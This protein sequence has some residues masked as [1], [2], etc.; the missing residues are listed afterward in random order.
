MGEFHLKQGMM[1]GV[2]NAPT[3]ID[4]GAVANSWKEWYESGHIQDGADPKNAANHWEHWREDCILMKRMGIQTFQL[5]VE[6]ARVEPEE[7]VF[8]QAALDHLKEEILLLRGLEIQPLL[9]LHQF[10]N[11]LWVEALGGWENVDTV[12]LY[13][14]FVEK[15]VR[16]VGHLVSDYVT[17][18]DAEV[19]AINAYYRGVWYPGKKSTKATVQVASTLA[20][21]HMR[22]YRLIHSI[23]RELGFKNTKVGFSLRF[24]AFERKG[25]AA[26]MLGVPERLLQVIMA[27]AMTMGRFTLPMKNYSRLRPGRYFDF[28]AIN[29][30]FREGTDANIYT[31]SDTITEFLEKIPE[32]T[33]MPIYIIGSCGCDGDEDV[34]IGCLYRQL[35]ALCVSDL[36]IERYYHRTFLD[37]FEWNKGENNRLGLVHVDFETMERSIKKSGTFYS[38]II[39]H[40]GIT[41]TMFESY[42]PTEAEKELQEMTTQEV[43]L[44]VADGEGVTH[45]IVKMGDAAS[46][47]NMER[48]RDAELFLLDMDGTLYLGDEVIDG[49]VAFLE[50]LRDTGKQFLYLTNNSSRAGSDYVARMRELGFPCE[51]ETVF[52]SGMAT[53]QYLQERFPDETVYPVGPAAFCRELESFGVNLSDGETAAAVVVGFDREL[54][55]GKLETAVDLLRHGAAF[56]ATNPDLVCPMPGGKAIPDCGSICALLTAATDRQPYYIGKPNR[57]MIDLL[58]KRYN[59]PNAKIVTVGDRLYTDIAIARN[60]GSV[61]VCVLSGE[62]TREMIATSPAQPDYVFDSVADLADLLRDKPTELA[63]DDAEPVQPQEAEENVKADVEAL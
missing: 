58:S 10:S 53:A 28:Q 21:A 27:E 50:T 12:R 56:I 30:A 9:T 20:A 26:A 16:T 31:M 40:G 8:S 62:T 52:T 29:F 3:E 42:L 51:A 44:D 22:A 24:G 48:L 36:P 39:A 60:A 15:V 41:K 7:G 19:Y 38:E 11:P 54:D 46:P 47:E 43:V 17:I 49:A 57:N 1:L 13:L 55:Y 4:G 25:A 59:I 37:G 18:N 61:S 6:W 32:G 63:A 33:N 2:A 35:E 23:R 14:D 5:G 45:R 34:R